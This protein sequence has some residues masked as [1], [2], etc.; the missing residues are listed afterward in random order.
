MAKFS[1]KLQHPLTMGCTVVQLEEVPAEAEQCMGP[2]QL[3]YEAC[4]NRQATNLL[5]HVDGM[6]Q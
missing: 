4:G 1:L 6:P 5:N 3:E 2:Q